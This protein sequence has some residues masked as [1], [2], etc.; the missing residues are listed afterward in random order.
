[1]LDS[2]QTVDLLKSD[3][4]LNGCLAN[5]SNKGMCS[6]DSVKNKLVC[7]CN[8]PFFLGDSC[9]IDTRP[10][11]SNTCLNNA[12]CLD[13]TNIMSQIHNMSSVVALNSTNFF[14]LCDKYHEGIYCESKIDVCR[15]ETCSG[16]GICEN[17]KNEAKCKCFSMYFGDKCEKKSDELKTIEEFISAATLIAIIIIILFYCIIFLMDLMKICIKKRYRKRRIK[18]RILVEKYQYIN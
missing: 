3:L 18:P 15:N 10:C 11:S 4:D 16:Y 14:C 5:C 13:R 6:F 17:L 2:S 1:M 8:S 9:Q 7:L 12:T